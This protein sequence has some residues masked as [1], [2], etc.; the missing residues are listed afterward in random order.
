MVH[1]GDDA[2][3]R[4]LL[5]KSSRDENRQIVRHLLTLYPVCTAA[6]EKMWKEPPDQPI[7][8]AEYDPALDRFEKQLQAWRSGNPRP[9]HLTILFNL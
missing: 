1:P 6:L 3:L 2:L 4:F 5:G 9:A 7:S 8:P